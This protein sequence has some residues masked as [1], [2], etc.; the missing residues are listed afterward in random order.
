MGSLPDV[1]VAVAKFRP[2]AGFW[3]SPL[4]ALRVLA[5]VALLLPAFG[6]AH[7]NAPCPTPPARIDEHRAAADR[8][9]AEVG[10]AREAERAARTRRDEAARRV[11][12]A[13]AELDSLAAAP[14][15]AGR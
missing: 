9:D 6:C 5:G 4:A 3:A 2:P 12:A 1:P 14:G 10:K 15:G 7:T 13:R 8:L 11:A